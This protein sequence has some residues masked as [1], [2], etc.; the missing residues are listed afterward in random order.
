PWLRDAVPSAG[1][2]S[3][4]ASSHSFA[5]H[6]RRILVLICIEDILADRVRSDVDMSDPDLIVDLASDAWF[7]TSN[8]PR[9]HMALARLRAIEHRRFLVHAT[10]T[11]VSAIVDPTGIVVTELPASRPTSAVA[12]VRWVRSQTAYERFGN[13]PWW[14]VTGAAV[15]L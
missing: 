7:E 2:L 5:F 4:G 13:T 9:L 8:V 14:I 10:N 1:R 12:T 15:V 6:G 3:A 11:G